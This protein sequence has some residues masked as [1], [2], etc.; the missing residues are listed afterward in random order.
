MFHMKTFFNKKKKYQMDIGLA[1]E[2][3]QNVFSA[4]D[5]EPNTI[6]FDKLLLRQKPATKAF[7]IGK[8][9]TLFM[10]IV[11]FF[12]PLA[13]K[14]SPADISKVSGASKSLTILNH[15][16]TNGQLF[17]QF[18][19]C[20][21]DAEES[22]MQ[23]ATGETFAPISINILSNTITFPYLDEET[24]IYIIGIDQSNMQILVSPKK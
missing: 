15:H 22:Y 24:N 20:A 13:F 23:I 5:K 3:L 18:S 2:T 6:P 11:T 12:T 7:T 10:L 14:P 8:W 16:I 9:L 19:G 1:N 21:I 17:L 4:C